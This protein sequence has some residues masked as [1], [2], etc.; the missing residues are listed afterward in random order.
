MPARQTKANLPRPAYGPSG[1]SSKVEARF[2]HLTVAALSFEEGVDWV[3]HQFG[4]IRPPTGGAHPR[5]ATHNHLLRLS[6]TTFLEVI[7]VD[8]TAEPP[9]RPRWFGLDS[10][11]MRSRLAE[12]PRLIGWVAA[13][14][15]LQQA[16]AACPITTGPAEPI[17]RGTLQWLITVPKD[18][19]L[20]EGGT[21][22][23]L[24]QWPTDRPHPAT[25]M[26]DLGCS[27]LRL[28]LEHPEP[29]RLGAALDAIGF[30]RNGAVCLSLN[31]SRPR[32]SASIRTPDG[33][34]VLYQP[35]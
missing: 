3:E 32:L 4:G 28:D 31:T 14:D 23:T 33:V 10:D 17:S 19:S 7:A 34:A 27:L 11:A 21:M 20:V 12:R 9:I 24:I 1:G 16:I 26:A 8:S 6:A 13:V 30:D 18:G 29:G 5:M 2:D 35:P 22:P 25:R 15:N